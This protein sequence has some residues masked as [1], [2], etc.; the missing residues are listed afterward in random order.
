MEAEH[1]LDQ[2]GLEQLRRHHRADDVDARLGDR[3]HR[4]ARD[5]DVAGPP[6]ACRAACTARLLSVAVSPFGNAD[7]WWWAPA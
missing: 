3:E 6:I 2:R 1:V 7:A 5:L 4:A